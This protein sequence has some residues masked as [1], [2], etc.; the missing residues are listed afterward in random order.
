MVLALLITLFGPGLLL[1]AVIHTGDVSVGGVLAIVAL[2]MIPVAMCVFA[3][4]QLRRKAHLPELAV[5]ITPHAVLFP[6]IDRLT[7]FS[8]RARAEEWAREGTHVEILAAAG[9]NAARVVFTRQDNGKRRRRTIAAGNLD[10]DPRLIV[11]VLRGART[12]EQ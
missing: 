6:A 9:L 2:L 11:D 4:R 3:V 7:A 5:T 10:V 1:L 8:P 12:S